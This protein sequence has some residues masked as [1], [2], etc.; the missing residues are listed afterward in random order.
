M[1]WVWKVVEMKNQLE[2]KKNKNWF[3]KKRKSWRKN[4]IFRPSFS[5]CLR[6]YFSMAEQRGRSSVILLSSFCWENGKTLISGKWINLCKLLARIKWRTTSKATTKII[7][8]IATIKSNGNR[9][10]QRMRQKMK[11]CW[12]SVLPLKP[13]LNQ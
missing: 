13:F 2:N 6:C 11:I 4:I 10:H 3:K 5:R 12:K 7:V 1:I 9:S 8:I